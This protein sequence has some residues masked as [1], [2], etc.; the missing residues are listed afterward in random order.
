MDRPPLN[1]VLELLYGKGPEIIKKQRKK[2]IE[3][4][5]LL[6]ETTGTR[7]WVEILEPFLERHGNAEILL[8]KTLE[9]YQ[10]LAPKVEAFNHF[11][12]L[13]KNLINM[14]N[15]SLVEEQEKPKMG[16]KEPWE[17]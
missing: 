10:A 15:I 9:E 5:N 11:L 17:R 16:E 1:E 8:G 3:A 13:I 2:L 12:K 14:G 7:G 4:S 6:K